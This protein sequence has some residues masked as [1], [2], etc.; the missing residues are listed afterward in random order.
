MAGMK[1]AT[2][3]M[4]LRARRGMTFVEVL[5]A[6]SILIVIVGVIARTTILAKDASQMAVSQGKIT[7]LAQKELLSIRDA[8]RASVHL[9]Q[10]DTQG[11]TY[12]SKVDLGSAAALNSSTLP[13][14]AAFGVF[15]K[16]TPSNRKTGNLLFFAKAVV[17]FP[18]PEE[19]V[20]WHDYCDATG[21]PG[22]KNSLDDV[23]LDIYRFTAYF[24]RKVPTDF[25]PG[26]PRGLDLA[27]WVSVPFADW[28]RFQDLDPSIQ[29]DVLE[30]L[31][32]PQVG[33]KIDYLWTP[34]EDFDS[35][36]A[37]IQSGPTLQAITPSSH[38]GWKIPSDPAY[39][40]TVTFERKRISVA[41]N[42]AQKNYGLAKFA[43]LQST[44]DGYPHGFEVQIIGPAS[45]RQ[46]LVHLTLIGQGGRGHSPW[47]DIQDV[48]TCH[49]L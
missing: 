11:N 48:V 25:K 35:A 45:A 40:R 44:G 9:F 27:A 46:V 6:A 10:R 24:L 3:E 34:G 49:D 14:I 13:K 16:D 29:A 20:Q 4:R 31:S 41:T 39:T 43:I 21:Q 37:E 32:T 33:K 7:I 38:P 42:W 19:I 30:A 22:K 47:V 28:K 18:T 23:R 17:P 15:G 5:I 36:F 26:S 12:W 1:T 8:L 2:K